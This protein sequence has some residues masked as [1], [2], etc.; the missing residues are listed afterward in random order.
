MAF[1]MKGSP[2]RRNFG[3]GNSPI[4]QGKSPLEQDIRGTK[5]EKVIDKV[6]EVDIAK[7]TAGQIFNPFGVVAKGVSKIKDWRKKK[8]EGTLEK[9]QKKIKY[10]G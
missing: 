5:L 8:M 3:I 6:V 7:K 10:P 9:V 2:M 1:K 4:K